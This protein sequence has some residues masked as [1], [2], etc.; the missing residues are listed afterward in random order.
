[1]SVK[2]SSPRSRARPTPPAAKPLKGFGGARVMEIVD[3]HATN[4]Y[5]VVYTVQFAH[6]IYVLHAFQKKSKAG[7]TTPQ[8]EIELIRHPAA[9][10]RRRA[11]RQRK[12]RLI[13]KKRNRK[14]VAEEGSGNVFA[15]LDLPHAEQEL[16]KARL[17]LQIY[18][19]IKARNLTQA[20]AGE[21]LGIRQPHVSALM[22][23][24]AGMFSVERLMEFLTALGQDV[25]ITVRPTRKQH[26]KLSVFVAA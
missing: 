3:R 24:R 7:V 22:R 12:A 4:T 25:E 1:M 23:N 9:V 6:R 21:I 2:L 8:K 18:R 17:T 14:I 10:G 16:L 20:K 11:T 26:G 15:D 5:R 13:M 19:I